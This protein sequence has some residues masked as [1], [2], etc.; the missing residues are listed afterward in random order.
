MDKDNITL[1]EVTNDG[2]SIHLYYDSMT[3]IYLAFGMSAFYTT[4][5]TEPEQSYSDEM[6]MPVTLLRQEQ[7]LS[8]R[9]NLELVEQR[10]SQY[11]LFRMKT[12]IGESG[13][14]D[15]AYKLRQ[16]QDR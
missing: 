7:I 14:A 2:Q 12:V 15:W 9:H 11:Y 16:R 4:L 10:P 8:L 13:Y 3:G 6:Q 5:V 1:G